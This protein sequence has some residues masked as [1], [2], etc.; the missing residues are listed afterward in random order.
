MFAEKDESQAATFSRTPGSGPRTDI[1]GGNASLPS[2]CA[3]SFR[4]F[5]FVDLFGPFSIFGNIFLY[6]PVYAINFKLLQCF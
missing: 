2:L 4:L 5:K 6:F 1:K 3:P